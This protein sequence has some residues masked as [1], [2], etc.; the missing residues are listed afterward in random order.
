MIGPDKCAKCSGDMVVGFVPEGGL[1]SRVHEVWIEGTP[2]RGFLRLKTAEAD[3]RRIHVYRCIR[4][5]FLESYATEP[6]R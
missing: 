6:A 1:G 5:G 2:R 4:C 3:V